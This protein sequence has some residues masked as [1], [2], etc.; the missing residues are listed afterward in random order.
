METFN[1]YF[2]SLL[3]NCRDNALEDL[4]SNKT[5]IGLKKTQDDLRTALEAAIGD[6]AKGIFE[7]FLEAAVS[8]KA[9]ECN[10]TLLCGL[11]LSAEIKRL[12]D[13]STAEYKAFESEYL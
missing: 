3:V 2:G 11:T 5:Y 9:M 10:K 7:K 13:A 8:V 1:E 6:E 12:Y 4:R